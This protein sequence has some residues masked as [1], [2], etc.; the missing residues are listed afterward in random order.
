MKFTQTRGTALAG[1]PSR[2]ENGFTLL[3]VLVALLVLSVGLLGLAALQTIGMQ[4]N[5]QSLER[6]QATQLAY[7][8]ID[9]VRANSVGRANGNYDNLAMGATVTANDCVAAPCTPAELADYDKKQWLDAI[10]ARLA[11]GRGA[12]CKGT[13][14]VNM[15]TWPVTSSCTASGSIYRITIVWTE[16]STHKRLDM[17]TEL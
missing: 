1:H 10:T 15:G 13:L 9:R 2:Q 6:T 3:E 7:E 5:T 14:T 17:E 16:N 11:E 8:I 12:I 4:V